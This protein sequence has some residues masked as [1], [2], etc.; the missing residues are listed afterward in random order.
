MIKTF[1]LKLIVNSSFVLNCL[2]LELLGYFEKVSPSP[3]F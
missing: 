3:Y 2:V 1:F